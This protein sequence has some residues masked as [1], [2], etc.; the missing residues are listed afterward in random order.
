[1]LRFMRSQQEAK[2]DHSTEQHKQEAR[3]L[4]EA[5]EVEAR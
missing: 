4:L 3:E 2:T 1:M 5:Q